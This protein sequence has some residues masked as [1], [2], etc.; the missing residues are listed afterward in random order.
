MT[1][2]TLS[3]LK[4]YIVDSGGLFSAAETRELSTWILGL[5]VEQAATLNHVSPDTVK[6]HRRA[7]REKTGQH[8]GI[9]VV[10]FCLVSGFIRPSETLYTA[11]ERH[12]SLSMAM[13]KNVACIEQGGLGHA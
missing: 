7:L 2:S 9:G 11:Y 13:Q 5:T 8:S 3:H 1:T 6:T 4:T 10:M 12:H